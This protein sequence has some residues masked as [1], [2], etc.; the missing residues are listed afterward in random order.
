MRIWEVKQRPLF[1]SLVLVVGFVFAHGWAVRDRAFGLGQSGHRTA[2]ERAD[3]KE[4]IENLGITRGGQLTKL[5][6]EFDNGD[7]WLK[8]I[9]IRVRNKSDRTIVYLQTGLAFFE[10]QSIGSIFLFDALRYGRRPWVADD[11]NKSPLQ[12]EPGATVDLPITDQTYNSIKNFAARKNWNI[13]SLHRATLGLS[14]VI[15]DDG[16]AWS[17][18]SFRCPDPAQPGIYH[19][20]NGTKCP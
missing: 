12:L 6:E 13:S 19:A 11:A 20:V 1:V 9:S 15:F 7:D 2:D 18:G 17:L 10:T 8:R 4:P 14:M 3:P 5:S 16:T